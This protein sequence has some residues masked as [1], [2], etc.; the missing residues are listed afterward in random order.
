MIL[1]TV[2]LRMDHVAVAGDVGAIRALEQLLQ[3][4]KALDTIGTTG[5]PGSVEY[6]DESWRAGAKRI[7]E[8]R[9][10]RAHDR[11]GHVVEEVEV[12]DEA[13]WLGHPEPKQCVDPALGGVQHLDGVAGA[14]SGAE[15]GDDALHAPRLVADPSAVGGRSRLS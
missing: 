6:D 8:L 11:R 10:E 9:A 13:G 4:R 5:G 3:L 1:R 7:H 14:E 12:V 2:A 15:I